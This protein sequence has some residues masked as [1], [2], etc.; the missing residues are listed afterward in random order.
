[1]TPPP[2]GKPPQDGEEGPALVRTLDNVYRPSFDHI[3]P[4]LDNLHATYELCHDDVKPD[5]ISSLVAHQPPRALTS[6][7]QHTGSWLTSA[8][9]AA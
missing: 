7:R 9:S 3:L 1:M 8:T 4:S 6:T 5:N 2:L